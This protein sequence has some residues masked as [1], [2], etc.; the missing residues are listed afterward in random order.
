MSK[1]CQDCGSVLKVSDEPLTSFK[2][3]QTV[4]KL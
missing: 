4:I 1:S 2:D 3:S